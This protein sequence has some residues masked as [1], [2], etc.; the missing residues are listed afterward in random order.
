MARA[1]QRTAWVFSTRPGVGSVT[2]GGAAT[3]AKIVDFETLV[4]EANAD[5][6]SMAYVT[7]PTSKGALKK[8]GAALTGATTIGGIQNAVVGWQGPR[9]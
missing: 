8:V 7:T 9:R 1:R 3:Y 2:F 4:A 5:S 6:D